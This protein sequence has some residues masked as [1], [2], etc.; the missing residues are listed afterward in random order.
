[1]QKHLWIWYSATYRFCLR[2][3]LRVVGIVENLIMIFTVGRSEPSWDHKNRV[4]M[5]ILNM[6]VFSCPCLIIIAYICAKF[7][8][9]S[10]VI[11]EGGAQK[12]NKNLSIK[13]PT[14]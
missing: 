9:L 13:V 11:Q 14:L 8:E 7:P 3:G 6:P 10:S 12:I 1:M 4:E 2:M 5:I